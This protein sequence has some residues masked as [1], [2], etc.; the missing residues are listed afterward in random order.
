MKI[1]VGGGDQTNR[2]LPAW[3]WKG[4]KRKELTALTFGTVE[5]SYRPRTVH[6]NKTKMVNI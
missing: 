4:N 6:S 3:H 1:G 5:P 2:W